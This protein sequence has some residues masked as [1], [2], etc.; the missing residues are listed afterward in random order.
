MIEAGGYDLRVICDSI[1]YWPN[2]NVIR[3][4]RDEAINNPQTL[5]KAKKELESYGWIFK[6]NGKT[7]CSKRCENESRN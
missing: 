7:Y 5:S 1:H 6:S 2:T 4:R 3:P